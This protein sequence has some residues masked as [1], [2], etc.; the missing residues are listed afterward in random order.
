VSRS[1]FAV[2]VRFLRPLLTLVALVGAGLGLTAPAQAA[3]SPALQQLAAAHPGRIVDAIVR[4]D[5]ARSTADGR[6]LVRRHGGRLTGDLHI[7]HGLAARMTARE[8]ARLARARGVTSVSLDAAVAPQALNTKDIRTAYPFAA[9]APSVWNGSGVVPA[10]GRGV[11]VAVV[12]TGIDGALPDFQVSETNRASRVIGSAVVN[13][14]ATSAGDRFGHGTHVAGILAGN[15]NNRAYGD[16]LDGQYVGVAPEADLISVKVSSG[17]GDATVLDVIYGLQFVVDHKTEYNIRVVNLSLE[18][19]DTQSAATDP[20]DAAAESAWF[21]GIVVV[22]AAGNRGDAAEAVSH[23]PGND[24]YVISVGALDDMGT[25]GRDDDVAASW[26][27]RGTTQDGFA[28]PDIYAPGSHIVSTLAPA[29]SFVGLCPTCV[30]SGDYF[31]AGG[32][33]MAAPVVAGVAALMLERRPSLTP[34]Q[35]KGLIA[36]YARQQSGIPVVDAV[37]AVRNLS[38]TPLPSANAG[39]LPNELI[40]PATGGIDYTKSS[41]SW[42]SWSSSP[43]TL[44]ANWARSSWSCNCS[45]TSAGEVDPTRSS[46]SRS[47]WSTSWTK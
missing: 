7:I 47:S 29:S 43:E 8:A 11:G 15:G 18:S 34:D 38:T 40:D 41:W 6:A 20:L 33:S 31:R 23:A 36:A 27:S 39:L 35:V 42:S 22:A 28:K 45:M 14:N 3:G 1:I 9:T 12:D 4:L 2:R 13:P 25:R 17:D 16:P 26:S 10:T 37:S 30:V 19:T 21:A 24:P 44:S 46:W 5:A 32:T